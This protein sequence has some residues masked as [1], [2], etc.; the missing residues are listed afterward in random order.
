MV[1]VDLSSAEHEKSSPRESKSIQNW[2]KHVI[3]NNI[4]TLE[5]FRM[6]LG[7][8]DPRQNCPALGN[9]VSIF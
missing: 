6:L 3:C 1:V 9:I 5:M 2:K 7:K 4:A 8:I